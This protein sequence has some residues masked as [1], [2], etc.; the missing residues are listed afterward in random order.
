MFSLFCFS[1]M[2]EIVVTVL[3]QLTSRWLHDVQ[4]PG[5]SHHRTSSKRAL[6]SS[7]CVHQWPALWWEGRRGYTSLRLLVLQSYI[8]WPRQ[9][10]A[11]PDWDW[12]GRGNQSERLLQFSCLHSE[13]FMFY[14][15]RNEEFV[16]FY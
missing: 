9:P 2:G 11:G 7:L 13:F 6:V 3:C 8:V 16:I 14:E 5:T 15:R 1:L 10:L 4:S 12:R